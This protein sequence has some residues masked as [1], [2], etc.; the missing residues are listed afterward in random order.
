MRVEHFHLYFSL[1]S[2]GLVV[3]SRA[4]SVS[5]CGL[6]VGLLGDSKVETNTQVSHTTTGC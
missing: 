6:V 5:T 2:L 3:F 4:L 1:L